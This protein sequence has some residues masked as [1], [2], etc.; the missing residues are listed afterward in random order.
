MVEIED[1]ARSTREMFEHTSA[2]RRLSAVYKD[3]RKMSKARLGAL[4]PR[5]EIAVQLQPGR[6]N[7]RN[8]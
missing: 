7:R 5:R 8:L 6:T 1:A 4:P 2:R 3:V